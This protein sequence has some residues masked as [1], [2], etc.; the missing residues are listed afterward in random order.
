MVDNVLVR[1]GK[2]YTYLTNDPHYYSHT[3]LYQNLTPSRISFLYL[4]PIKAPNP[5]IPNSLFLVFN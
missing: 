2:G 5:L 4:T 3:P 1:G